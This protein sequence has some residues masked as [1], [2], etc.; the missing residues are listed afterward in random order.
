M[1]ERRILE[2]NVPE[3]LQTQDT[4][5]LGGDVKQLRRQ[6]ATTVSFLL[7]AAPPPVPTGGPVS[8]VQHSASAH[9]FCVAE[10]YYHDCSSGSPEVFRTHEALNRASQSCRS[11]CWAPSITDSVDRFSSILDI[12]KHA[13]A[14]RKTEELIKM[15]TTHSVTGIR[16]CPYSSRV[17]LGSLTLC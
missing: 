8:Y 12:T 16:H 11:V 2:W 3:S 6:H 15:I 4:T 7:S 5:T 1:L 14:I 13:A 9:R 17:S 10:C